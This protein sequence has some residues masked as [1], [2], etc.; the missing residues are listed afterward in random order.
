MA[1]TS[2]AQSPNLI[3]QFRQVLPGVRDEILIRRCRAGEFDV[4]VRRRDE[5]RSTAVIVSF[6]KGFPGTRFGSAQPCLDL[7]Q[8]RVGE[9][10]ESVGIHGNL[11]RQRL[12]LAM[13]EVNNPA[14]CPGVIPAG[15][16]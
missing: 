3:E 4:A 12:G 1:L 14:A 8:I 5:T 2:R 13:T 7:V 10:I 11:P 16:Q 6:D 9:F 15:T